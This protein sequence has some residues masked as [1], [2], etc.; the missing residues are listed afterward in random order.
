MDKSLKINVKNTTNK[1]VLVILREQHFTRTWAP[2]ATL[3]VSYEILEEGVFDKGFRTLIN[4]GILFIDNTEARV[5][6]GLQD[7]D[8]P[9]TITILNKS[10]M[11]RMLRVDTLAA[12]KTALQGVTKEQCLSLVDLAITEKVYDMEKSEVLKDLCGVD[13]IK[14]LQMNAAIEAA[15][16]KLAEENKN[17]V[18]NKKG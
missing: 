2:E 9:S 10:Q 8:V 6:L 13:F 17:D 12:F 15:A 7:P 1:S 16:K 18:L 11:L 14:N 5:E 4:K 3:K